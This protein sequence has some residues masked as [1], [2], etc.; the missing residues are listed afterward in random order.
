MKSL[1]S[2]E[3]SG[4]NKTISFLLLLYSE[5]DCRIDAHTQCQTQA[6]IRDGWVH[7]FSSRVLFLWINYPANHI[8][9]AQNTFQQQAFTIFGEPYPIS[10]TTDSRFIVTCLQN[11]Q[12]ISSSFYEPNIQSN[13]IIFLQN[14]VQS[15]TSGFTFSRHMCNTCFL[16][17]QIH[18]PVNCIN[19]N[20]GWKFNFL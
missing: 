16:F 12:I 15:V 20:F 13:I 18:Y 7:I 10:H 8:G 14:C 2:K 9:G 4:T 1:P 11:L 5:S 6:I 17:L 19:V 3:K